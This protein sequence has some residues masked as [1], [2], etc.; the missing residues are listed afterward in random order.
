MISLPDR[1]RIAIGNWSEAQIRHVSD[2]CSALTLKE[3]HDVLDL[4]QQHL[5]LMIS[6]RWSNRASLMA[7]KTSTSTSRATEGKGIL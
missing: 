1:Y 2:H 4:M 7:G 5:L 3:A 6:E